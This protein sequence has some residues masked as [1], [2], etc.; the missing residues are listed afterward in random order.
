MVCSSPDGT[1][2]PERL[3]EEAFRA[4]TAAHVAALRHSAGRS[5]PV[6]AHDEP[7]ALNPRRSQSD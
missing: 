3:R 4:L 5:G 6:E 1:D 2:L 7:I